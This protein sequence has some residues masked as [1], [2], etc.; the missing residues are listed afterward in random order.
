MEF[1][2]EIKILENTLRNPETYLTSLGTTSV[3]LTAVHTLDQHREDG[4]L[5]LEEYYTKAI[6][7]YVAATTNSSYFV[8]IKDTN[9]DSN[10]QTPDEFKDQLLAYIKENNIKLIIDLHGAN[11]ER[12]FDVEF[13]TL[14]NISADYTTIKELEDAFKEAGLT[15]IAYN[16]PFKGGGITQTVFANTDIDV[17]QIE[18]NG[19]CRD[20]DNPEKLEQVCKALINFIKMYSNYSD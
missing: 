3:M 7:R 1:I 19:K 11:S 9:I 8:K 17:I 10:S 6:A 5:K 13:G 12:D 14:N 2:E 16:E 18:I 4:S 15:N 20:I